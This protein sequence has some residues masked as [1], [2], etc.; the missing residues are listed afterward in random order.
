ML[1]E[2]TIRQVVFDHTFILKNTILKRNA[3]VNRIEAWPFPRHLG[4]DKIVKRTKLG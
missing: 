2:D 3:E 4:A 1:D